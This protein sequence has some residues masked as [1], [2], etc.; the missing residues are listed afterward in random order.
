MIPFAVS[1]RWRATTI[2]AT[3]TVDAVLDRSS[4]ELRSDPR[5]E[6]VAH[7]RQ[8]V[9]AERHPGRAVVGDRLLP[10]AQRLQR[11]ARRGGSSGSAICVARLV[12]HAG[13]RDRRPAQ[14]AAAP[15]A[16]AARLVEGAG[17]GEPLEPVAAGAGAGGEVG[18]P[19]VGAA[20]LALGDQRLHL[21]LAH[22]LHVAEP[23][24]TPADDQRARRAS[25]RVSRPGRGRGCGWRRAAPTALPRRCASWTSA[26]GG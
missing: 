23:D 2:P 8:R 11:A 25:G 7:Q 3:S 6:A 9:L 26:S 22:P 1:G 15:A 24:P 18:D 17:P 16:P 21:L 14:S 10:L 4:S 5:A 12:P 20:A 19:A 13:P